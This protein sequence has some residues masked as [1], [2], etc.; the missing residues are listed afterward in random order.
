MTLM[1]W[2]WRRGGELKK[3]FEGKIDKTRCLIREEFTVTLTQKTWVSG[4]RMQMEE[5]SSPLLLI[6]MT[7]LPP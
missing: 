4:G 1:Q 6:H 7:K 3:D 5:H 2:D